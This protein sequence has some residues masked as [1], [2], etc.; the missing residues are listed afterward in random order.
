MND[1]EIIELYWK[2]DEQA[3]TE[4]QN[5][6]GA[7]CY[8]IANNILHNCEDAEECVNDIWLRT[9]NLIPPQKPKYLS[10]FLGKI[11]RNLSF[12]RWR[13]NHAKKRGEQEIHLVL[14]ELKECI[15][16]SDDIEQEIL[17]EELSEKINQFLG[18][19]KKRD[20]EIFLRRYYYVESTW[21]IANRYAIKESHVLVI[22]SRVRKKL[23][24]FLKKEGYQL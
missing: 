1:S 19:L 15:P 13:K 18:V 2:R 20:R 11:T 14:D 16:A 3:I 10:L 12:D 6:Y 4:S 5:T 24:Q 9:W 7:Y 23:E 8:T 22:L 17:A 21:D